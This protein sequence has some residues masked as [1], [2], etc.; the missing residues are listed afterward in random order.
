MR[1]LPEFEA[2]KGRTTVEL[3][4]EPNQSFFV[5][6][7]GEGGRDRIATRN[8]P[9]LD[10]LALPGGPWDISFDPKW[11]GPERV[12][13]TGL[14]DWTR[15]PEEGI[16]YYSGTAV[17]RIEFDLPPAL[18]TPPGEE[19]VSPP[20]VWMDLGGVNNIARVRLNGQEAGT[21]WCAPLRADVTH[22][23]RQKRNKLEITVA[24]LWP[25]R[26]IGDENLPPNGE[27]GKRGNLVR[28]PDW[29]LKKDP[30]TPPGRR[31]FATWKHYSK[32]SP[33]LPSGLLGPVRLLRERQ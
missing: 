14:E 11:G 28:W 3:L 12:T 29:I 31:S 27:F 16:R 18:S 24:N 33:L 19:Q 30:S 25:N 4:F 17:Y 10:T 5:I 2:G 15:R 32:D 9:S 1:S 21:L 26:L 7:T 8:F 6:F 13:F 22:S 23:L 20:A